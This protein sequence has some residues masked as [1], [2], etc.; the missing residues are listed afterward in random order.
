MK[1]WVLCVALVSAVL[2]K[3]PATRMIPS[4]TEAIN[5]K[6]QAFSQELSFHVGIIG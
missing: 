1:R 6:R 3:F 5:S 2:M 4:A